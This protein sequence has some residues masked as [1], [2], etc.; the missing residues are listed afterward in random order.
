[1]QRQSFLASNVYAGQHPKPQH[2]VPTPKGNPYILRWATPQTSTL[3]SYTKRKPPHDQAEKKISTKKSEII[4]YVSSETPKAVHTSNKG[5][6]IFQQVEKLKYLGVVH[7]S[8]V[9]EGGTLIDSR[10]GKANAVL[11]KFYRLCGHK[12]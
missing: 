6:Y 11:R 8:R 10:I 7:Y 5:Q 3:G 9:T 12:T 4:Q 1:M 2:W